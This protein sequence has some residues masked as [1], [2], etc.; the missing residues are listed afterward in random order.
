[1]G[2][3]KE[4]E[5][6]LREKLEVWGDCQLHVELIPFT[7]NRAKYFHEL[8]SSSFAMML[9]WHEGFGL[10]GW[11]AIAARVPLILGKNSGLW[12]FLESQT[13]S[14]YV[15][16][17][18]FPLDIR[19]HLADGENSENHRNEDVEAVKNA[20]ETIASLGNDARQAAINLHD[21]IVEKGWTWGRA[22]RDFVDGIKPLF[23]PEV[24][25]MRTGYSSQPLRSLPPR[26]SPPARS[27]GDVKD[28]ENFPIVQDQPPEALGGPSLRNPFKQ[29]LA[30]WTTEDELKLPGRADA[31]RRILA[32]MANHGDL[33]LLKGRSGCGKSSL[34]QSG[35]MRTLREID[36]SVLAPFR[37]TELMAGSGEGDA[38]E[39]LTRLIAASASVPFPAG[40]PA[41]M[42]PGNYA[43][44]LLTSLESNHVAL[45]L[46][47]DQFEEIID[48]LKL[49][50][51]RSTGTPQHGWWLVIRFLKALCASPRVRLIATLE[52]AREGSVRDLRIGEAMGLKPKT[53]NVDATDDTIAEIAQSGFSRAG[54]PLDPE[55][56]ETIKSKWRAF[57]GEHPNDTASP[58]PLACLFLHRLYDRF[59]DQAGATAD[60][61]LENAFARAGLPNKDHLLTLEEIGG[62]DAIA[63]ADVIQ[64]LAD[65]AWSA[66][67]GNP[68]FATPIETD[69][70]YVVLNNFLKPLVWV[71]HRGQLQLRTVVEIDADAATLRE[72]TAFRECRLLVPVPGEGQQ[73]LRPVHQALIDRWSP[74]RRWLAYRKQQLQTVQRFCEDAIF[75]HRRGKP[76]P[77]EEDGSTL[78]AATMTLVER[79]LDWRTRTGELLGSDDVAVREQALA[80]FDTA[81][82]PFTVNE[83]SPTGGTY[84]HLAAAYH[85]VDLLR[86]FIAVAPE[87][88]EV[89][90]RK[91]QNLLHYAAWSKGP[92]VPFLIDL[93]VPTRTETSQWNVISIP[94]TQKLNDDFDAMLGHIGLDDPI[95]TSGARRMIH[96]AAGFGNMH[97]IRRLI[98][99]GAAI[100][101]QDKS[102]WTAL[103]YAA[104]YN[105]AD[106]FR[107]LLPHIDVQKEDDWKSTA[108][109]YAAQVGAVNVLSTYLTEESGPSRLSAML[110][111]RD[112]KGDTPLMIAARYCQPKALRVLL[113]RDLGELGDPSA[114]A[115]RSEEGN[116]LFHRIFS[117]TSSETP[118]EADRFRARTLVEILLRDARLEPNLPNDKGET[119][120]D[121]GGAFPEARRV[122]RE[123]ERVPQDYAKMSPAM[124]IEDLSSRRPATVLR[125]LQEAPQAL[126]DAH[127]QSP[128]RL[129]GDSARFKKKLNAAEDASGG[130]TGLEILVRL[131]NYRVLAKLAGDPVHWPTLRKEMQKLLT[132]AVVPSAE[133]LRS[134][135]QRRFANG[136]VDTNEGGALLGACVD[137]GDVQTARDLVTQGAPLTFRR[138]D[139]GATELHRAAILG[140]VERFQSVLTIGPFALPRDKWGR[141]PSDLAAESLM[142]R[143]RALE[144]NMEDPT[145]GQAP[146]PLSSLTVGLPPFLSLEHDEEARTANEMEM[147]ILQRD[148]EEEWGNIDALDISVFD[149]PFHP[150]VP[151][152]ELRPSSSTSSTGRICLLLQ[153]NKLYRLN[154][155][156]PPIH[157]VNRREKPHID[158]KT[159]LSYLAFFCF[160]VRGEGGPFL[161]VDRLDN[162]I[163]PDLGVRRGD[164]ETAFRPPRVWG[165][166]EQGNCLVS[167]LVFYS[168]A[169][170]FA[171]FS[172]HP[173]GMIEMLDDT[174]VLADLPT[175]VDAPLR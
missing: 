147:A 9:S 101:V 158:E 137:A 102:G 173:S 143:F 123:D 124:R 70:D 97:V 104:Y 164:I 132:V 115:H 145:E 141:C 165:A 4:H 49:E 118:T 134:A 127:E 13:G 7:E 40:G 166:D 15:G 29:S 136:E 146:P 109:S 170:F 105:Q 151:L 152:I 30:H 99:S 21:L 139:W 155:S 35:V 150:D 12:L 67:G 23:T 112:E 3:E 160:F 64:N 90:D 74:A 119:P 6:E 80:V 54:L 75:W 142:E 51:E 36:G 27:D 68:D 174:H 113:Q 25:A 122:L 47:L 110:C 62:E 63:F 76:V 107:H 26:L 106:A 163:L 41:A 45:V 153:G 159:A 66:G 55:V 37:P 5:S 19:G 16:K 125:L 79:L 78:R 126:T 85:R 32:A 65:E 169:V 108:I 96:H 148:W 77:L 138:D 11:E 53:I 14:A 56:I 171:D 130:E 86:R 50:R 98:D 140:E 61:R 73:R 58:L 156:S 133:R 87:C 128:R 22:A 60:E 48:E 83:G 20:I 161:I 94:I 114:A 46:G 81:E 82:D 84:A 149:L 2:V 72:R 34:M 59:A 17:C 44:R 18:I 28:H 117:G 69:N 88:Q 93:G 95:E 42:R 172:V 144:A 92:A 10:V 52:S 116:T 131:K 57:E 33:I 135:L 168:D 100:D 24:G 91:G 162:G 8:A 120:F 103:H 167:S 38:L 1:M 39:R 89:E 154:G 31:I 157:E 71:D 111:H 43:K 175:R 129:T 121:L